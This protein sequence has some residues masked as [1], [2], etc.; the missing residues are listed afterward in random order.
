[1]LYKL[2]INT[3]LIINLRSL[4]KAIYTYDRIDYFF[5]LFFSP[6][7]IIC[8]SNRVNCVKIHYMIHFAYKIIQVFHQFYTFN[9]DKTDVLLTWADS[10]LWIGKK[11][12]KFRSDI[13]WLLLSNSIIIFTN[14]QFFILIKFFLFFSNKLEL[15]RFEIYFWSSK[16]YYNFFYLTNRIFIS[17]FWVHFLLLLH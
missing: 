6:F 17:F 7:I 3:E 5:S 1:M 13:Y 11:P 15:T 12:A 9:S 2:Q 16:F 10:D 8:R 14:I 4:T